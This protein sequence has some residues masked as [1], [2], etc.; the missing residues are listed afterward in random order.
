MI[1]MDFNDLR[2]YVGATQSADTDAFVEEC[3]D[4]AVAFVDRF[5]GDQ[6]IPVSV[7]ELAILKCGAE[8]FNQKAAKNG[9]MNQ[10]GY[11]GSPV[12]IARDPMVAA[13]PVLA[14][15]VVWGI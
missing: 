11:D 8:M 14:P 3:W 2:K 6:T 4:G 10:A 9:V 15:W 13:Y 1:L 5:I 12:R 7:R